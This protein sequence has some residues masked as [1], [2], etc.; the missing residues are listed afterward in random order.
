MTDKLLMIVNDPAFFISHRLAIAE[1]AKEM[2]Y[3][4]HIATMDGEAVSSITDKGFIHHLLP[5]SRSG[6]NPFS[7]LFSLFSVWRLLWKVKP[8]ILHLVTIKPVIY[9]GIA[10]RFAPV[11]GVVAA[12]SGLG[13]VFVSQG[14]KATLL[15][16]VVNFFYK[17]ALGKKN[18]R[19]I[20]Q[21][22]D[23]CA[24][25]TGFSIVDR[26]KAEMIRGSGVDLNLYSFMPENMSQTPVVC[27]AA[28]LLRD[29]GVIEFVEAVKILQLRGIAARFQIV[30][31]VDLGN[32]ATIT[33]AEI[34]TWRDEGIIELLGYRKDIGE[35]FTNAN[36]VTLPSYREG[37]PK[38]LVEAAA[39][40]RAVVTTDVPGCRD[41]IDPNV[42]GLLVPVRDAMALADSLEELIQNAEVRQRMGIAGR[43]L[44]ERAFNIKKIVQQHLDIYS[45]LERASNCE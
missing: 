32:P 23:D 12:V 24:V 22:P 43:A 18:L 1:A 3:E 44:A 5:L 35:L 30:G 39:C 26:N 34:A 27:F 28:R 4:T 36:I 9:G 33:P 6:S 21:N 17:L 31:D 45:K 15:R 13:F 14:I 41:A 20:F 19:V 11:K 29:K 8:K 16:K 2:G 42:T 25:L 40:G 37:L 7:E 38:V 10:A